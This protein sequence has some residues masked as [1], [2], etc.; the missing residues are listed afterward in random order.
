MRSW[1]RKNLPCLMT[2]TLVSV[3]LLFADALVR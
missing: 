3:T 1:N 2:L